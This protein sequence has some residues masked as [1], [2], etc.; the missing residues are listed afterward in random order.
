MVAFFNFILIVK[1]EVME[2]IDYSDD[3]NIDDTDEIYI[4]FAEVY[5]DFMDN[6]PYYE[7][8]DYIYK[9]LIKYGVET[10]LVADLA[11]GTGTMTDLLAGDGYDMIGVDMSEEMLARARQKCSDN[12]L[13]LKQDIRELDLYGYVDAFVCICD[14]MNYIL[15]IEDIYRVFMHV[16]TFLD[17]GGVFIFDMK[18]RYFYENVLGTRTF[19]ENRDNASLF[20][21]NEFHE[22]TCINEYMLTIYNLA[23]DENYLFERFD[24]LHRQRA[25]SV[26][27]IK[28]CADRAGLW[29]VDVYGA[30]SEEPPKDNSERIYFILECV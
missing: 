10:G 16:R 6:I 12:V 9:L 3:G 22:D 11:C 18:T 30:F 21:E 23:D 29:C 8:H 19:A 17:I 1:G 20:W 7:W 27:E 4:G 26:E 2:E 14:G 5:D 24:E 13:L 25:Y 28:T 15:D